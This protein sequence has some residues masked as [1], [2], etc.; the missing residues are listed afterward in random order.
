MGDVSRG[1]D[2]GRARMTLPLSVQTLVDQ[3]VQQLGLQA[4][5]P[6]SLRL[7]LD[8]QGLVQ[9]VT[10]ELTFRRKKGVDSST[11]TVHT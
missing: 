8:D 11:P 9:R 7:D 2:Q 5:R 3:I 1:G 10:P 4:C 6:S